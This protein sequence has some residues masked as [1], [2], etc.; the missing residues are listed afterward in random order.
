VQQ[1]RPLKALQLSFHKV[2]IRTMG[3]TLLTKCPECEGV[4]AH[5]VVRTDPRPHKLGPGR[6]RLFRQLWGRDIWYRDRTRHCSKCKKKFHTIE[7]DADCLNRLLEEAERLRSIVEWYA[8]HNEELGAIALLHSVFGQKIPDAQCD[9]QV[10]PEIVDGVRAVIATLSRN[11]QILVE[12]R[13]GVRLSSLPS[14]SN[15]GD[16]SNIE[17]ALRKLKHPAR[18]R[19]LRPL[20]N[21]VMN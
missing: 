9:Q 18:L 15:A 8:H 14:D 1:G 13:Y 19:R 17:K 16:E 21:K 20:L 10:L 7:M 3:N 4:G 6:A 11:E 12:Q 5:D 2:E